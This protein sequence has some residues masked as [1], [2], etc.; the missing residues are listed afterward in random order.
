MKLETILKYKKQMIELKNRIKNETDQQKK[1]E[2][3]L[4]LLK[5]EDKLASTTKECRY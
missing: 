5:I 4:K 3:E 1:I 2:L